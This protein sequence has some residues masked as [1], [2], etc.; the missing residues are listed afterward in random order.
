MVEILVDAGADVNA[1][2]LKNLTPLH[3]AATNGHV[4]IVLILL[5]YGVSL[6]IRTTD[7]SGRG[8]VT[9]DSTLL[10]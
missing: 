3:L 5:R 8:V 10:L 6:A 2:D 9:F 7:V 4:K 1:T